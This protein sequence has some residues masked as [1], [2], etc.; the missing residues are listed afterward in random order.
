MVDYTLL[1]CR[2]VARIQA[3][4]SE[5]RAFITAQSAEAKDLL[6]EACAAN[7]GFLDL[8]V[9]GLHLAKDEAADILADASDTATVHY[10]DA[11]AR[12][13]LVVVPLPDQFIAVLEPLADEAIREFG[14]RPTTLAVQRHR[15]AAQAWG[16][17]AEHPEPKLPVASGTDDSRPTG[18]E[19]RGGSQSS[20]ARVDA[21]I[22]RVLA[23]T[24]RQITRKDIWR[25]AGYEDATQ[26]QRF[27]RDNRVTHGSR[28]KFD[29]ILRLSP[30]EFLK[31]LDSMNTTNIRSKR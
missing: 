6:R 25:V 11:M 28:R 7:E 20:R 26:F 19:T 1:D 13:F 29:G 15:W 27:E 2:A 30:S 14:G 18:V 8:D 4:L 22:E 17:A 12:E 10:F 16:S 31:R 5:S 24:Q 21:F 3:A 9:G 23:E